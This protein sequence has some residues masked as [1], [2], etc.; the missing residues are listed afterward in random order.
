MKSVFIIGTQ[1]SGSN[2]L[3]LMLNQLQAIAS[4]HPPHILDRMLPLMDSYGDLHDERNFKILVDDVCRLVELNPVEWSDVVF[5]REKIFSDSQGSRSLTSVYGAVYDSYAEQQGA[6]TWICKSMAN[7]KYTNEIEAHF[8]KPKYI[9]LYRDGRDVALSF[10]KA[11]V[12]EKHIYNIAKDWSETQ[13]KALYLREMLDEDQFFSVSYEQL[14]QQPEQTAKALCAFLAV[15][16]STE[17]F[18][19]HKSHEAKNAAESSDLWGNVTNPILSN[20]SKKYKKEMSED[21]LRIFESVAGHTLDH[22]NYERDIVA[23]GDE[24]EFPEDDIEKFN[25]ENK[26]KKLAQLLNVDEADK[27]RRQRQSNLLNEIRSRKVA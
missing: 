2:L 27:E 24:T 19:Y 9:Y 1:R 16:F 13:S 26:R 15:E 12:G 11:V 21:D 20:N 25:E 10:Q 22:L 23:T 17:M 6:H 8:K 7:I 18:D 3:R 5:D 14:T 4:P